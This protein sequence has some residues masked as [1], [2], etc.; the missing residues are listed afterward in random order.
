[1]PD[2]NVRTYMVMGASLVLAMMLRILP[3]PHEW[4]IFNP[5]WIALCLIYWTMAL[6][7]RVGVGTAWL[8]GLF[9]DVLTGRMLGQH[10]VAYSVIAYLS[11]R[12]YRRLRLY[13]LPQQ[14]LW[15]LGFLLA[16]QVLVY[17]T[18]H[19]KNA[20]SM[21]RAYWLP[22]LAGAVVWPWVRIALRHLRRRYKI[23]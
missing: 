21:T 9:A 2:L 10:A 1:M 19:I 13:P 20:E 3:L 5:D 6:P 4:F 11:L 23:A 16:G 8:T 7:E 14:C 15:V 22:P 17:W 12:F 18:Q